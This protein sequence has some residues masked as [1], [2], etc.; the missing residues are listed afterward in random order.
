MKS[1]VTL[2]LESIL[3]EKAEHEGGLSELVST[4]LNTYFEEKQN[5][6]LEP[7][8]GKR[9]LTAYGMLAGQP[10]S[11]DEFIARKTEEKEL[12]R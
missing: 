10:G 6:S 2:S 7:T 4:L 3:V 5:P 1:Q 12:E 9:K 8:A 11:V